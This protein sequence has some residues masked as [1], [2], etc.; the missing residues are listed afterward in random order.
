VVPFYIYGALATFFVLTLISRV[1]RVKVGANT[2]ATTAVVLGVFAVGIP[3]MLDWID[4]AHLGGRRMLILGCTT[5]PRRARH[6]AAGRAA[7]AG[8]RRALAVLSPAAPRRH[9]APRAPVDF[10][11]RRQSSRS[12]ATVASAAASGA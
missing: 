3:L 10:S 6:L 11:H 2:I 7:A 4:L 9:W 8:R 1:L 12:L 5:S